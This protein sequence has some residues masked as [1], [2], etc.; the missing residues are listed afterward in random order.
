M[1]AALEVSMILLGEESQTTS[2]NFAQSCALRLLVQSQHKV[3][4]QWLSLNISRVPVE[5]SVLE[6]AY[7]IRSHEECLGGCKVVERASCCS[8]EEELPPALGLSEK[9]KLY[10][11]PML[12]W[13]ECTSFAVRAEGAGGPYLLF[14]TRDN[15]LHTLPF[16]T[17]LA[18]AE[19]C[20]Q[21]D[22]AARFVILS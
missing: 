15:V 19:S 10:W 11:G 6:N 1:G 5:W 21:P 13:E 14:I 3:S 16:S 8:T 22:A 2:Q 7:G 17:L 18:P 12:L 20:G 9:G 4:S